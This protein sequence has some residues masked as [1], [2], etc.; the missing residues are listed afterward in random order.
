MVNKKPSPSPWRKEKGA[1]EIE[2]EADLLARKLF[3][4]F[5]EGYM[6]FAKF[7][8]TLAN[9]IMR[10]DREDLRRKIE[11]VDNSI[12]SAQD[13]LDQALEQLRTISPGTILLTIGRKPHHLPGR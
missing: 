10:A 11:A 3:D 7:R 9:E 8:G 5:N 6:S 4:E 12:S 13:D 2:R 1:L